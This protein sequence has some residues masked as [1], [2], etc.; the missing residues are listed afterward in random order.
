MAFTP[1]RVHV[2]QH[3][4]AVVGALLSSLRDRAVN[5]KFH[6][7]SYKQ[8][9][10]WNALF[11]QYSPFINDSA[12]AQIY[13]QSYIHTAQHITASSI[14]IISLGCGSGEKDLRLLQ[15]LRNTG[16]HS[17]YTPVDVSMPLVVLAHTQAAKTGFS[18]SAGIVCD[19]MAPLSLSDLAPEAETP[20]TLVTFFG[21]IPNFEP[22]AI[23]PNIAAMLRPGG[24]LL[25]SGNLASGDDYEA[26]VRKVLPQYDNPST[27]GWLL[28][29]LEDLGV[30]RDDG[31]LAWTIEP[32]PHYPALRRLSAYFRFDCSRTVQVEGEEFAFAPGEQIRLFFSYRYTVE[33]LKNVLDDHGLG[34]RKTFIRG[35]EAVLLCE[36]L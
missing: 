7:T 21:M 33:H 26:G 4:A 30:T 25:L 34:V 18:P 10:R 22:K 23:L 24:Y 14:H 13:E 28:M 15:S 6:Y 27:E 3:P 8:A 20:G 31:R 5:H 19:L 16:R 12:C 11:S 2:S 36:R 29:F 17:Q 32:D 9:R 35:E 1:I